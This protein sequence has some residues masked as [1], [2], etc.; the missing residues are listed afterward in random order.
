MA[1]KRAPFPLWDFILERL[2]E[3]GMKVSSLEN[4]PATIRKLQTGIEVRAD[5]LTSLDRQ[6]KWVTGDAK[7]A[8][9]TGERPRPIPVTASITGTDG[10]VDYVMRAASEYVAARPQL[11]PTQVARVIAHARQIYEITQEKPKS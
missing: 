5:V 7:R 10:D 11:D 1:D 8:Q 6:L 9:A 4:H 3:L 2:P